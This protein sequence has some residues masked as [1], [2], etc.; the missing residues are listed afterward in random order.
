M[1]DHR[2][3]VPGLP[4]WHPDPRVRETIDRI[5]RFGWAVNAVSDICEQCEAAG[6]TPECSFAYTVGLALR[7]APE[8]AVYGLPSTTAGAVLN[9]MSDLLAVEYWK[10]LVDDHEEIT[11]DALDVP[12]RLI[13]MVDTLDLIH[14]R[15]VFPNVPALQVV[16]TDGKLFFPW[17]EGYTLLDDQQP[18]HGIPDTASSHRPVGP[19]VIRSAGGPN[20][21]QRRARKRRRR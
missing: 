9:E 2:I 10:N 14:A 17:E 11:L 7:G 20:R 4:R 15:A 18:V 21:A 13:E 12:V 3:T 19:R 16:W 5:R 6:E 8:L 1:T